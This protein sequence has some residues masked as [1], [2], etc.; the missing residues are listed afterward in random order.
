MKISP[1][2]VPEGTIKY[3]RI[4]LDYHNKPFSEPMMA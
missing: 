3:P 2:F 4:N 1:K